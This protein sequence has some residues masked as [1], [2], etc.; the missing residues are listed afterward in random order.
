MISS[1]HLFQI[2]SVCNSSTSFLC[3][4]FEAVN[5]PSLSLLNFL[6]LYLFSYLSS[7]EEEQELLG[8][9]QSRKSLNVFSVRI[10]IAILLLPLSLSLSTNNCILLELRKITIRRGLNDCGSVF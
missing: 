1:V 7:R 10:Y 6:M 5:I 9:L 8:N 4:L 2:K 3:L